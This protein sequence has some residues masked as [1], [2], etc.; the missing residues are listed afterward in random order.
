MALSSLYAVNQRVFALP[1]NLA[2]VFVYE[3]DDYEKI[4]D[5]IDSTTEYALTGSMSV[6]FLFTLPS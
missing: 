3:D 1:T 6:F 2:Q 5:L 4:L